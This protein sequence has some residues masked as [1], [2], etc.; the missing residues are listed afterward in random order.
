MTAQSTTNGKQD[1]RTAGK[2]GGWKLDPVALIALLLAAAA[3]VL[4]WKSGMVKGNAHKIAFVD[5]QR[6]LTSFKEANKVNK[7][8][9]AADGKWKADFKSME[10]S[11]KAYMDT[12]TVKFDAADMK[13]K[14]KMQDELAMRNQQVNNFQRYHVKQMQDMTQDKMKD[15]YAKIN[16]FM[17]EYG[18]SKGYD[19]IFGTTNGS[20]LYGENTQ[21]DITDEVIQAL[22]KKYD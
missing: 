5:T 6:L 2:G 3:L 10:D 9:E 19:V 17:K 14:K 16:A 18:A 15:V 21:A 22:S 4:I 20:I 11:L 1:A 12:M 7:E 13:T 8:L